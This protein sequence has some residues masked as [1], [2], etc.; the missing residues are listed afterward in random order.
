MNPIDIILAS[1]E[2]ELRNLQYDENYL[3][4][5]NE[6]NSNKIEELIEAD[7]KYH[8]N[9]TKDYFLGLWRRKNQLLDEDDCFD[10]VKRIVSENSTRTSDNDSRFFAQYMSNPQYRFFENVINGDLGL[11]ERMLE[12]VTQHGGKNHKSLASKICK[13]LNEWICNGD[14]YSI[15]DSFVRTVLPYYLKINHIPKGRKKLDNM[16]YDEIITLINQLETAVKVRYPDLD[17]NKIDHILWYGYR[18]DPIRVEIA[19]RLA[20]IL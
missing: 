19:K 2:G 11:V 4:K 20:E 14:A 8:F 17:K 9:A 16:S 5:I 10:V 1:S 13:Y 18:S 6:F 15:N 12:Y 7:P 3:I